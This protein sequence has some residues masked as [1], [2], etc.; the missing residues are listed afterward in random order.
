MLD[1]AGGWRQAGHIRG[2]LGKWV[3]MPPLRKSHSL[4]ETTE[5]EMPLEARRVPAPH[6]SPFA[7]EKAWVPREKQA[8]PTGRMLYPESQQL[9][10]GDSPCGLAIWQLEKKDGQG[11][12][13]A[14]LELNKWLSDTGLG[15]HKIPI[16]STNFS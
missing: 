9:W 13:G 14:G 6:P 12:K 3:A 2:T 16:N 5:M 10:V 1:G 11:G 15:S 8:V 4:R 7:G